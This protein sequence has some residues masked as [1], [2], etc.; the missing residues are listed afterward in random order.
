[1]CITVIITIFERKWNI[2]FPLLLKQLTLKIY[3]E[4]TYFI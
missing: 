2:M 4:T 1:M 3:N